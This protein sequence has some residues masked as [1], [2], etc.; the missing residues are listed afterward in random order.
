MSEIYVR[1]AIESAI[2]GMA[3][4]N[5]IVSS[6]VATSTVITT[7]L[8]HGLSTGMIVTIVGH[9]GSTPSI[10][11]SYV[12]TVTGAS[13]FTV[14]V[15]VTVAG[16]GGGFTVTAWENI[17]FT[18]PAPIIPYQVVWF[19]DFTTENPTMGDGFYRIHSYFQI[20]LMYPILKGT[21][22]IETRAQL[23]KDTFKRGTSFTNNGVTVRIEDTPF[24]SIGVADVD[25][26]KKAV[27]VRYWADIFA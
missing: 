8:P 4:M 26:Y 24:A 9:S 21:S 7:T 18:K 12:V 6:S 20:D 5:T 16:T 1:R 17:A 15:N 10:N 14:P 3:G 2:N 27:K 19:P 11:S 13:T 25:A 23:V 22:A